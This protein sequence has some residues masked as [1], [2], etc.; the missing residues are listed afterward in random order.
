MT[1]FYN[2]LDSLKALVADAQKIHDEQPTERSFALRI[3]I[4]VEDI[5][6]KGRSEIIASAR[7]AGLSPDQVDALRH[8]ANT[9][10]DN[11][12]SY[13]RQIVQQGDYDEELRR[14][15][16]QHVKDWAKRV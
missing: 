7:A 5:L 1:D 15:G 16:E 4:Y 14:L 13:I 12:R 6:D 3:L 9:F 11:L 2:K 10:M 8:D